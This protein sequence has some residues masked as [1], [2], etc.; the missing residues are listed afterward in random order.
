M[1]VLG[2]AD[3]HLGL[4]RYGRHGPDGVGS[5]VRDFEATLDR[6]AAAAVKHD[7]A[8]VVFGGDTFTN[9]REGPHEREAVVRTL[10]YLSGVGLTTLIVDGNHDGKLSVGSPES[11]SLRWLRAAQI[12]NVHV[13]L[14]P[15]MMDV[16]TDDGPLSVTAYPYPHRQML[17]EELAHRGVEPT[18]RVLLAGDR[19]EKQIAEMAAALEPALPR[20]FIGHLTV[21]DSI[22]GSETTMKMGWDVA[23]HRN[24]LAP[25]D[26]AI[27]GHIHKFQRLGLVKAWYTGSPEYIDFTEAE[28]PKGFLL[29][30]FERGEEPEVRLIPSGA[31]PMFNLGAI[32]GPDGSLDPDRLVSQKPVPWDAG[33]IIRVEIHADRR[34]DPAAI[35]TMQRQLIARGASFVKTVTRLPDAAEAREGSATEVDPELDLFEATRRHLT[36]AGFPK[37]D[38]AMEAARRLVAAA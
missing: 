28:L 31:R 33:P 23:I 9:R 35:A 7:A 37:I 12:P 15:V 19:V 25:F 1:R 16:D 11:A 2:S 36:D 17:D 6:F 3:W 22:A 8:L 32:A 5:R 21:A 27:L 10:A 34:L 4:S 18:E 29:A 20:L 13:F 14:E 26:L 38:A 30:D 24:V